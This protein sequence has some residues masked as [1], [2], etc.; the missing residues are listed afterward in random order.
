VQNRAK[1][2]AFLT[3][4]RAR[5]TP[6]QAGL[7][8]LGR[9][10]VEGLRRSEVAAL[11]GVSVE[12]YAKIERGA[13]A[14]VSAGVLEAIA[15]ALR[16]DDVERA[17][18]VG[19]AQEA[20]GNTAVLRAR[21]DRPVVVRPALQWSLDNLT[22]PALVLTDRTDTVAANLLGRAVY[23]DLFAGADGTPNF[24]RFTFLDPVARTLFA[25]WEH[26]ADLIVATL[27]TACGLDARDAALCALVGDLSAASDDFRRR[28]DRHDIGAHASGDCVIH[29]PVVGDLTLSWESMDLRADPGLTLKVF[30][31]E[32]GSPTARALD[33]LAS[34]SLAG[35]AP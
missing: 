22:A 9:R 25:D 27:Q 13:L 23:R 6:A 15:R 29:H 33:L 28:W 20:N 17:Y 7:P 2:R 21:H 31:A 3:T 35:S 24:A 11:A 5:I 16:L 19:L 34:W 10:R 1:V 18:L 12:Y 8:V 14:G 32:P 4:R 30:A 26:L